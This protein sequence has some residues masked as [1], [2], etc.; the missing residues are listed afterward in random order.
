MLSSLLNPFHFGV[1]YIPPDSCALESV[2]KL[3]MKFVR[4][5]LEALKHIHIKVSIM[6]IHVSVIYNISF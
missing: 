6:Y 5:M 3:I 2:I 4:I 1:P